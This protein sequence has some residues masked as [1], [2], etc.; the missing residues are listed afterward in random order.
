MQHDLTNCLTL[1]HASSQCACFLNF[2][3]VSTKV[4]RMEPFSYVLKREGCVLLKWCNH[5]IDFANKRYLSKRSQ[6]SRDRE[7]F[8]EGRSFTDA[9]PRLDNLNQKVD[10]LKPALLFLQK[11]IRDHLISR[12]QLHV[13]SKQSFLHPLQTLLQIHKVV[14]T[15]FF[16]DIVANFVRDSLKSWHVE[17]YWITSK[18]LRVLYT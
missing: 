12:T 13:K 8:Y 16:V 11:S 18:C 14:R 7:D 15:H 10:C 9:Y 4:N 5:F 1:L 6:H 3:S 17:N 2:N